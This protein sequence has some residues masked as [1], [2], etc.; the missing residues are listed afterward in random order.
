MKENK[1]KLQN[2]RAVALDCLEKVCNGKTV[3]EV[4]N[5][6]LTN[7]LLSL[8]D[9]Q[10]VADLVYGLLRHLIT[11]KYILNS[12]LS[13]P[14]R[15]PASVRNLL[16][17][18]VYSL[19]Y[20]DKIPDYAAINE[21]VKLAKKIYGLRIGNLANAVLR[22]VQKLGNKVHEPDFYKAGLSYFEAE[23]VY[24][25][26]PYPISQLWRESYGEGEA[27]ALM[28]RSAERPWLGVRFNALNEEGRSLCKNLRMAKES[29]RIGN[30]GWA[31]ASR[32]IAEEII[33]KPL[34]ELERAGQLSLQSPASMLILEKLGL[35]GWDRPLW[36]CCAGSG[37]KLT[38]MLES[39]VKVGLA[40]DIS[41]RRLNNIRPFCVRLGLQAPQLLLDSAARSSVQDWNGDI[42]ADVPCSGLGTLARRPDIKLRFGSPSGLFQEYVKTQRE[43]LNNLALILKKRRKLAYITCTLNPEENQGQIQRLLKN[44]PDLTLVE[45]WQTPNDAEELDGMYGAVVIK[46]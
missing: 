40:S 44:F 39:N 1:D 13:K 27:L 37:I 33:G 11:L 17:L 46:N 6:N 42:L 35:S 2:S 21:T 15:L 32:K 43:I 38:A 12:F 8:Q 30:W 18:G 45:E 20:Q 26:I 5:E 3:Q 28:R 4:L 14:F 22:K 25:G 16:M 10:L 31:F 41:R 24:Y 29:K 19:I 23:S 7:S 34:A 36:D 9:K